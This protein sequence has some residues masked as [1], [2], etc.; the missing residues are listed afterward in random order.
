MSPLP[1]RRIGTLLALVLSAGACKRSA[2]EPAQDRA[3]LPPLSSEPLTGRAERR[4]EGPLFEKLDPAGAGIDFA[5][6]WD[7]SGPADEL[8][9]KTGFTGG[10]V[11]MGDYDGDGLC[12]IYL[13]RPHGGGRLYRNLGGFRFEDATAAAGVDTSRSWTTG[14]CF[15]DVDG[16]DR[17]D[18]YVCAYNSDN[19][20]FLNRGGGEFEESAAAS[21]LNPVGANVKMAF[22]DIDLDG[23]LDAYLVTNRLEP[24]GNPKVEYEGGPGNYRVKEPYRELVSIIN[25]PG[26]EQ[27]FTKAGQF[28]HLFRNELAETGELRFTDISTAAGIDGPDHGLDALSLIHI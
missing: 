9:Q 22:A 4:A 20:L 11:A 24:L 1:V 3:A 10:G 23:D 19:Y 27:K 8:M 28:D 2:E 15:V 17:L 14:A 5:H 6:H 21:A 25:L 13:T 18:L 7:P 26:G 12:D 16:D